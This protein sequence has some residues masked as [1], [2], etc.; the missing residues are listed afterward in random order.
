MARLPPPPK[1]ICPK[2]GN[3]CDAPSTVYGGSVLVMLL[4]FILGCLPGV[5]Y[6]VWALVTSYKGCARCRSNVLVHT[7]SPMGRRLLADWYGVTPDAWEHGGDEDAQ[8]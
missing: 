8:G 1:F 4:C 7:G 5:I 3:L 2:C 6:A